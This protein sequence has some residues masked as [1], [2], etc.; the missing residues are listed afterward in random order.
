M[1]V[2]EL[3]IGVELELVTVVRV[4]TPYIVFLFF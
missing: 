1:V 4:E 2:T 3:V